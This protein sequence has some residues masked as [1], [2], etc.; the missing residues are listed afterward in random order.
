MGFGMTTVLLNLHNAGIIDSSSL[1]PIFSMGL[2]YGGFAQITAGLWEIKKGNTFAGLA[3]NS[4]G[5]FWIT[6][7][8]I[9]VF[10][11]LG[12]FGDPTPLAMAS[13]LIIWGIFTGIMTI[14]T[15]KLNRVI[16][17][18]FITLTILFFLLGVGDII[19]TFNPPLS[20]II[21]RIAGFEGIFCGS[22]AIYLAGAELTNE[23]YGKKI[24]P[25][26][27]VN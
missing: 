15:F 4:F 2:F 27:E 26:G 24:F 18:I 12:W 21:I 23:V 5:W 17:T 25:I 14:S 13:Y 16:Q 20:A 3:F 1:G 10:P 7:V 6:L 11:K 22:T 8:L 19:S 9:R